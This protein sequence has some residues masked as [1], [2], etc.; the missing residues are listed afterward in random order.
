MVG[1]I[2][3]GR[4]AGETW[5]GSLTRKRCNK[6]SAVLEERATGIGTMVE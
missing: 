3:S 1:S 2:T 6:H 5:L 4:A